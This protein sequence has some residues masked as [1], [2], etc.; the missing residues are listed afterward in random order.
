MALGKRSRRLRRR[1]V[2]RRFLPSP[3]RLLVVSRCSF[4]GIDPHLTLSAKEREQRGKNKRAVMTKLCRIRAFSFPAISRALP[5]LSRTLAYAY[6][7]CICICMFVC[8]YLF[9]YVFT[10][11]LG[12]RVFLVRLDRRALEFPFHPS[13]R[14]AYPS[15]VCI[16][17]Q[18]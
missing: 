12:V 4:R 18:T 11:V 9:A 14:F 1:S 8:L 13:I 10:Y 17:R 15:R 16:Y 6:D 2:K 5:F 3:L 7:A